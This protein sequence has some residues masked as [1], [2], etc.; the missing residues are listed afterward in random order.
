MMIKYQRNKILPSKF[1]EEIKP[2][3]IKYRKL[4]EENMIQTKTVIDIDD[5]DKT[6]AT[7]N[8]YGLTQERVNNKKEGHSD[9]SLG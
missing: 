8:I 1:T 7:I 5:F 3:K 6:K 4:K 2:P 9:T